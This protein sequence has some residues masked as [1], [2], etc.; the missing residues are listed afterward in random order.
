MRL[1]FMLVHFIDLLLQAVPTPK[2][3]GASS[4]G[5]IDTWLGLIF[6]AVGVLISGVGV[7][8]TV[9]G[10]KSA[11]K[12]REEW[13]VEYEK[14]GYQLYE[15]ISKSKAHAIINGISNELEFNLPIS[16]GEYGGLLADVVR[17]YNNAH[18]EFL[19]CRDEYKWKKK[20]PFFLA[21]CEQVDQCLKSFVDYVNDINTLLTLIGQP[22]L[23]VAVDSAKRKDSSLL[24]KGILRSQ[25]AGK[26][27]NPKATLLN[28]I[29]L[30]FATDS[31]DD[32]AALLKESL[33]AFFQK[34]RELINRPK[35]VSL[36]VRDA[37]LES[38][39]A[40]AVWLIESGD[41]EQGLALVNKL[42]EF[43]YPESQYYLGKYYLETESSRGVEWLKKAIENAH[44]GA[45]SLLGQHYILQ[46]D[47]MIKQEGF[48]LLNADSDYFPTRT[49]YFCVVDDS[50]SIWYFS[51]NAPVF[52]P[53]TPLWADYVKKYSDF[54]HDGGIIES[55]SKARLAVFYLY[56][57]GC[58]KDV[59]LA[60]QFMNEAR[61]GIESYLTQ[62]PKDY[63]F[64]KSSLRVYIQLI[65]VFIDYYLS[66]EPGNL[67]AFAEPYAE[68]NELRTQDVLGHFYYESKDY[69]NAIKWF[70]RG[71]KSG[72][73][74]SLDNL[75]LC[76]LHGYGT[77]QNM[78]LAKCLFEEAMEKGISVAYYHMGDLYYHGHI[79]NVTHGLL[80]DKA[81]PLY[82]RAA[83][84]G[85]ANAVYMLGRCYEDLG[86]T[87]LAA[88][89]YN[90]AFTRG[91]SLLQK[92]MEND[93]D[94][95]PP[96]SE[97]LPH[98]KGFLPNYS[99]NYQP[100]TF[101]TDQKNE[102]EAR[103]RLAWVE[104][105]FK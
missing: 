90:Q 29:A 79:T 13:L 20:N 1:L 94:S 86:Q 67:V 49:E 24:L 15:A 87:G 73:A 16:F 28:I 102:S 42:A 77:P 47:I 31:V 53:E 8:L 85:W 25:I 68:K 80:K 75:G 45:R 72:C 84:R 61:S 74:N 36:N 81:I 27:Y 52:W 56:G 63:Y 104:K 10:A 78:N 18:R 12:K 76:Y 50:L 70:R 55:I 34:E 7:L 43:G 26:V 71:V 83:E 100:A 44:W 99:V 48:K 2:S 105:T 103:I 57:K 64:K 38:K 95:I 33:D 60:T 5:G 39:H 35:G 65:D 54:I 3:E 11:R 91:S 101:I 23:D 66:Y 92:R 19:R 98:E 14:R 62:A 6:G 93:P 9:N 22:N 88:A 69:K 4:L 58:Q 51:T 89:L 30:R 37:G 46:D 41:C 96:V 40:Y 17:D 82:K 32:D 21:H 97:L 59:V